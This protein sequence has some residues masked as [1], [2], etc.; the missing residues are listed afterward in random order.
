MAPDHM[1]LVV[2]VA[3]VYLAAEQFLFVWKREV[4]ALNWADPSAAIL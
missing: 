1:S 3:A 2:D 4:N